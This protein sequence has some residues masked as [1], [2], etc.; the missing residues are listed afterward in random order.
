MPLLS[1]NQLA[2]QPIAQEIPVIRVLEGVLSTVQAEPPF[3]FLH[4]DSTVRNAEAQPE[5]LLYLRILA[6]QRA[7][8]VA[9]IAPARG[10]PT[11][12]G[13]RPASRPTRERE[14]RPRRPDR[15]AIGAF[16]FDLL[17][18]LRSLDLGPLPIRPRADTRFLGMTTNTDVET[19][20]PSR[21]MPLSPTTARTTYNYNTTKVTQGSKSRT[22]PY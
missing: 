17:T 21:P 11:P 20:Q 8:S 4:S 10:V 5:G 16:L 12:N 7:E 3:I 1:G 14:Q 6:P 19:L 9:R 13:D 22:V 15:E 18:S 2:P